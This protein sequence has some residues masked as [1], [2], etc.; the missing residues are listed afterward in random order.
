MAEI[1]QKLTW[2][3]QTGAQG[4]LVVFEGVLDESS[5]DSLTGLAA[6]LDPHRATFDLAGLRRI[7]SLG[8]RFWMEFIKAIGSHQLAYRRCAPAFV[9]QLNSILNFRGPAKVESILA[10]YLCESCGSV[11]YEELVVDRDVSKANMSVLPNRA[12]P[13]CRTEM[14]FDDIPERYL[15]FLSYL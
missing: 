9:E 2:N 12:C 5:R 6:G 14:V 10:P 3:K 11:R 4:D 15:Q 13:Q 1:P 7:N 8:V